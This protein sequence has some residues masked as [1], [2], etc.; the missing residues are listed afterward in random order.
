MLHSYSNKPYSSDTNRHVD[1][2]NK[3]NFP[4]ISPHGYTH[5]IFTNLF[6]FFYGFFIHFKAIVIKPAWYW[7]KKTDTWVNR[8]ELKSLTL[9]HTTMNT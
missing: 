2:Q 6:L 9:N 7:H 3:I 1:Q 8:I 4:E 5:L